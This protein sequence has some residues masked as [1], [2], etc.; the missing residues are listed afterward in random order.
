MI[1]MNQLIDDC[2]ETN[3]FTDR[4]KGKKRSVYEGLIRW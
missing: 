2:N 1:G 3:A 4:A